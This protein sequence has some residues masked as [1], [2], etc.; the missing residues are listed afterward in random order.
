MTRLTV[1]D[2]RKIAANDMQETFDMKIV[3]AEVDRHLNRFD[4]AVALMTI[5]GVAAQLGEGFPDKVLA[6]TRHF[7]YIRTKGVWDIE[8]DPFKEA[9]K[10]LRE[11][12]PLIPISKPISMEKWI[13]IALGCYPSVAASLAITRLFDMFP[14]GDFSLLPVIMDA[15]PTQVSHRILGYGEAI[16]SAFMIKDVDAYISAY[17]KWAATVELDLDEK[18]L[19]PEKRRPVAVQA[20]VSLD[21]KFIRALFDLGASP[22]VVDRFGMTPLHSAISNA[23]LAVVREV[24][25]AGASPNLVTENGTALHTVEWRIRSHGIL[26]WKDTENHIVETAKLLLDH[27]ADKSLTNAEGRTPVEELRERMLPREAAGTKR[28]KVVEELIELLS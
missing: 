23:P 3:D 5:A 25:N 1:A 26:Q 12:R 8:F 28:R 16:T 15:V 21:G 22:N 10:D 18:R 11:S 4:G 13:M 2:L 20:A 17:K 19:L 27:G 14:D 7:S 9:S 6:G 24:L